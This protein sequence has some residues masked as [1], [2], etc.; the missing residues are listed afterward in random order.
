[1]SRPAARA[2]RLAIGMAAPPAGKLPSTVLR[3]GVTMKC[4]GRLHPKKARRVI[5]GLGAL[6]YTAAHETMK[7][8]TQAGRH[9]FFT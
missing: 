4:W 2:L 8:F 7:R 9:I 3:S 1:M 6:Y 5:D